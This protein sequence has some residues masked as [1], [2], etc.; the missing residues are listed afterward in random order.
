MTTSLQQAQGIETPGTET[1]AKETKDVLQS[2]AHLQKL[3]PLKKRQDSL[4]P[5]LRMVHRAI[6]KALAETG[7]PPRQAEIAAML[8]SK[9]SAVHGL[10][11]LAKNDLVILDSPIRIDEK[12]HQPVAPEDV[13]VVGAYPMTT[14]TTPHKVVIGDHSVNAMCA[15]DA[16]VISPMFGQDTRI[17]SQCHFTGAPIRI[18]QKGTE[19]LEASPSR[20]I[21]VGIRWQSLCEHAAHSLCTEMV[22][23]K[24]AET[25]R[26]W[27]DTAPAS[28]ELFT[29]PEAIELGTAFFLPLVEG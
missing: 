4:P 9:R 16:L 12:T 6:L 14:E 29:L 28:I 18:R 5:P 8:G 26:M 22:F 3:L 2:L 7:H 13:E 1:A 20:D 15:V 17:E 23:L 10:S 24:D 11:I 25:A 27:R 21:R 19:I